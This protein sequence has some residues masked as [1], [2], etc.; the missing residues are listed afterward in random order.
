[1]TDKLYA[2]PFDGNA[3]YTQRNR[4]FGAQNER[5][6]QPT[7]NIKA[8]TF[9]SRKVTTPTTKTITSYNK[10]YKQLLHLLSANNQQQP[11]QNKIPEHQN[12]H[13]T[14]ER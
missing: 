11:K 14:I 4:K 2:E 13:K 9:Q 5:T 3:V 1:M 7:N 12:D 10:S 6:N 8:T